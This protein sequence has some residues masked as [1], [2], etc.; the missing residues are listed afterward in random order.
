MKKKLL[1]SMLTVTMLFTCGVSVY[2]SES[3]TYSSTSNF[4]VATHNVGTN[5][6]N[7]EVLPESTLDSSVSDPYSPALTP[8]ADLEMD[9]TTKST[10][11]EMGLLT[12]DDEF[13]FS[14]FSELP[15]LDDS[16]N[17]IMPYS[18]I[19]TDE[20]TVVSDTTATPWRWICYLAATF[21]NG[22]TYRGTAFTMGPSVVGTCGHNLYGSDKGGWATSVVIIAARN[23]STQPYGTASGTL[24]HV[25]QGWYDSS[26]QNEDWGM[27][28]LSSE[29]G[30]TVGYFGMAI[31]DS[32]FV[33]SNATVAGYPK[34]VQSYTNSYQMW[35]HSNPITSL[36]NNMWHYTIDTT[37]G[38][39]GSPIYIDGGY[40]IGIHAYGSSSSNSGRALDQ[41]LYNFFM[42]Y[43]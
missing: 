22:Y 38:N 13:D 9:E 25:G 8:S 3:S 39:S 26:T 40:V 5:E 19:G 37:G 11:D 16:A 20:R 10:L 24:F 17:D 29:L 23:D 34:E 15:T 41:G 1:A 30:N 12:D 42:N 31:K 35:T 33:G 18:V 36:T 28:E 21:P 27:V 6:T 4:G 14:A 2:A 43:R 32:S 7:I